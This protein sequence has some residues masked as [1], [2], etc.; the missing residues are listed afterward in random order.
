VHKIVPG[1]HP[2]LKRHRI[3]L[4]TTELVQS[5]VIQFSVLMPAGTHK[6]QRD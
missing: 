5:F 6:S 1:S 4:S 2:S 3:F